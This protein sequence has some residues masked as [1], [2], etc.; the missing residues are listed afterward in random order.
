MAYGPLP[1]RINRGVGGKRHRVKVLRAAG[2]TLKQTA[3]EAGSPQ[4]RR[5][6]GVDSDGRV[7]GV[8]PPPP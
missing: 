3:A 7:G 5:S 4:L 6:D 8:G 1:A 2:K